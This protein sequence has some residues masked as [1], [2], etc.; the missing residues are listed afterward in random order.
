MCFRGFWCKSGG[1]LRGVVEP[2]GFRLLHDIG[3]QPL[4]G[5]VVTIYAYR[6]L[7]PECLLL[8]DP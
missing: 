1:R 4:S 7:A 2:P 6:S 8:I 5:G 3:G